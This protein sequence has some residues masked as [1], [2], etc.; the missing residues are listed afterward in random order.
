M[1]ELCRF[2]GVSRV[3]GYKWVDRYETGGLEAL[4]DQ[5]R[6]PHEHPNA[7]AAEMEDLVIG[8]REKHPSWG[9]AKIRA[10]LEGEHGEKQLPAESTIG[11]ILKRNGLTVSRKRRRRSGRSSEPL[12]QAGE[13]NAVWCADYKGWFRTRDGTRIDPLVS[14]PMAKSTSPAATAETDPLDEPPGRRS[15]KRGLTGVP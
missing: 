1:A 10:R 14:V 3:T 15:G 12:A 5:S 8:V 4:R 2:Y 7:V 11:A 9:A 6:A 13:C